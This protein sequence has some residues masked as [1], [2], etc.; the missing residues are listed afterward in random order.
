MKIRRKK[1]EEKKN[2][3]IYIYNLRD[4]E[5][6]LKKLHHYKKKL[7]QKNKRVRERERKK[8]LAYRNKSQIILSFSIANRRKI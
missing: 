4:I 1:I 5:I 6:N 2:T 7:E 3:F 8:K